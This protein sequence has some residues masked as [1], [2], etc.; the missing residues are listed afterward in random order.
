MIF[1]PFF[2]TC[3]AGSV[4][5]L[6]SVIAHGKPVE[7]H[8]PGELSADEIL[9][10]A[11]PF[12]PSPPI[13]AHDDSTGLDRARLGKVPPPG[14]HPRILISPEQLPDLRRRLKETEVGR[15]A[16]ACLRM[17]IDS[18]L[19]TPGWG[20]DLY[21][22]LASGNLQTV[23]AAL[24]EKRQLPV[25]GHYQPY[26]ETLG[27]EALRAL[28]D[29]DQPGG[30]KVATALA[31]YSEL[32]DRA[33]SH[34][35][36]LPLHDDAWR[37][38]PDSTKKDGPWLESLS[39]RD[40][41]GYHLLGYAYDFAFP[42]MDESQRSIT[43]RAIS[44]ATKGTVW[45]GARLPHHFRNWNWVAIGFH[46][47]LMALAIEGEEGYDPRVYKLGLEIANDYLT[48]GIT[49]SGCSTEAVG[50]TQF[51]LMWFNPFL[52]AA[53]RRGEKLL[54][55]SHHRAMIDW[56]IQSLDP[57]GGKWTSHGDGGGGE[58][59]L[60]T[61]AMW[62]YFFPND[63]KIDFLWQNLLIATKGKPF[64]GKPRMMEALLYASDGPK[65]ADEKPVDYAMGAK[66]NPA[67]T[68]F[69]PIRSSLI[70]RNAW[71][72]DAAKLEFECRTDSYSSSHEHADR[73]SFTFAAMGRDWAKENFR[74]PET[75]H[76]SGVLVD[77]NGQGVQPGPGK[78]LG[79]QENAWA[80]LA[81]CD[82]KECYDSVWPKQLSTEG[83]DCVRFP[84]ER[85]KDYAADSKVVAKR[86]EGL[87]PERDPRPS[88]AAAWRPYFDKGGGPRMWDEDSWPV[89]YRH[90]PVQRA[91]RTLAFMRDAKAPYLVIVDDI[92]KD[93]Q[94]RLYEWLMQ[95]GLNTDVA[96][97]AGSDIILCDA[98]VTRDDS[99][100]S[101]PQKGDRQLLVRV[102]EMNDPKLVRDFQGRP[103]I[104]LET[105]ERKD[106]LGPDGRSFGMDK[107]LVIASRS[108]AP[109]YKILLFPHRK[110]EAL[111]VT[112]WNEDKTKLT[113]EVGGRKDEFAFKVGP[114]GRTRLAITSDGRPKIEL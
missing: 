62:R 63:P 42:F 25:Q 41:V 113:I 87:T 17:R 103:S 37:V 64:D 108:V 100:M 104:R 59:S 58:P 45:M 112:T 33:L 30:R 27:S 88:V 23:E 3:F 71:N 68:W 4:L 12:P 78:W 77:G 14:V 102:L 70:A 1:K 91:F 60:S 6:F 13:E 106:T 2:Q 74:S 26:L 43:R 110:G 47:P 66:L 57:S 86:F 31:T 32:V 94:E 84:Y 28:I 34:L 73:G 99:G 82:A 39:A 114:D 16:M 52:V 20:K 48:Y 105:F 11:Y 93:E 55:H 98:G 10:G 79:L 5:L 89:R 53:A 85:W 50:Y 72:T 40:L 90:N 75:R 69:D 7:A 8:L 38:R 49:A 92:Q 29:E 54:T 24:N 97:M 44:K 15:E 109:S 65:G 111:P 18:A 51:G 95:T 61:L 67:L 22:L 96:A 76:H 19:H 83:P 81:A 9:N 46:N 107:R 80:V 35:P 36:E 56:Y 21:E 101:R